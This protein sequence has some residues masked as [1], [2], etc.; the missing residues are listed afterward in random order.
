[1]PSK[2][3]LSLLVLALAVSTVSPVH[4]AETQQIEDRGHTTSSAPASGSRHLARAGPGVLLLSLLSIPAAGKGTVQLLQDLRLI[5]LNRLLHLNRIIH[6]GLLS[7]GGKNAIL[8][9]ALLWVP[10]VNR[11]QA[12]ILTISLTVSSLSLVPQRPDTLVIRMGEGKVKESEP[13][14]THTL[15]SQAYIF[16]T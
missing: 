3:Y 15:A 16:I 5:Q 8:A 9:V 7:G 6:P 12:Y 13:A 1:M 4:C 10:P 2:S 11:N 14:I